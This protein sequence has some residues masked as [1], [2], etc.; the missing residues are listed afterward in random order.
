MAYKLSNRLI[1]PRSYP[2]G[3]EARLYGRQGC[4]PLHWQYPQNWRQILDSK[5]ILSA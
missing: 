4:L 1:M 3:W 2:P 5:S